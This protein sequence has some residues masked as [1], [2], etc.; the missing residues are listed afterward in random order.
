ME[1]E[2][3]TDGVVEKVYRD[4]GRLVREYWDREGSTGEYSVVLA[5]RFTVKVQGQADDVGDLKDAL[6]DIDLRGLEALKGEGV[7]N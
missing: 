3:E 2:S 7:K 5:E 6:A 4:D 1:G